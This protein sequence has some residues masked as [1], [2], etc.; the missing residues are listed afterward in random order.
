MSHSEIKRKFDE[1]VA[2]SEIEKFLDTPVKRYSS[3]MY[4]RL[5]FAVAAH[6]EP[7]ILIVDEVLA[8][9]DASFQKKC[10]GKMGE[11]SGEGRTILFVSHNIA[12]LNTFC[13]VAVYFE[14]GRVKEVGKASRV[15]ATYS[16]EI[17]D[18]QMSDLASLRVAGY[19]E[20]IRFTSIDLVSDVAQTVMFGQPIKYSLSIHSDTSLDC[21]SIGSSLFNNEGRCIASLIT[22]ET[23]SIDANESIDL[24]LRL[25]N[26]NLAPGSYY[27]SFSVGYGGF[28]D[29][30][31]FDLELLIGKPSFQV[32]S[33]ANGKN[34]MLNWH[35][36]W[37]NIAII[38]SKL[39]VSTKSINCVPKM[40]G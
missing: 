37:G 19:G 23:F 29:T 1:I 2:F 40:E 5:A 26:F 17:F 15:L 24:D 13:K 10:L 18:T 30:N 22:K 32:V 21:L 3:G 27:A 16:S 11:V 35:S 38:E 14:K 25:A 20:K 9:G 31:R 33:L 6:L 7:E 34:A 12:A 28:Q 4:V 36:S 8:V 39:V